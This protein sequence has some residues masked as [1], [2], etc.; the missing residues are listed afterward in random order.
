[1]LQFFARDL[2]RVLSQEIQSNM[3]SFFFNGVETA[4][5]T[6]LNLT[7]DVG[8]ESDLL[9]IASSSFHIFSQLL[10]EIHWGIFFIRSF[11]DCF[12][13]EFSDSFRAR[14]PCCTAGFRRATASRCAA[15]WTRH[16]TTMFEISRWPCNAGV[17][18]LTFLNNRLY[19]KSSSTCFKSRFNWCVCTRFYARGNGRIPPGWCAGISVAF[20]ATNTSHKSLIATDSIADHVMLWHLTSVTDQVSQIPKEV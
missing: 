10:Y 9:Q 5:D 2:S 13:S 17:I 16:D 20:A 4:T 14:S 19:K 6:T 8:W 12:L 18:H 15:C 7:V 1:M 3:I 11:H